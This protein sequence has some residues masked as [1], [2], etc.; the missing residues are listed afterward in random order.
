MTTTRLMLQ[1]LILG[2]CLSAIGTTAHTMGDKPVKEDSSATQDIPPPPPLQKPGAPTG[3]GNTPATAAGEKYTWHDGARAHTIFLNPTTIA[4]FGAPTNDN[5]AAVKRALPSVQP[6]RR[7][8]GAQLWRLDGG[9]DA[10]AAIRATLAKQPNAKLSPVFTDN[11]GGAGRMRA[12]PGNVIVY[13]PADWNEAT[14][15]AWAQRQG[16]VI[17]RKMDI[18]KNA[19]I[20]KTAPGLPALETA[21]R[22]YASGEVVRA[23]PDWWQET[24]TR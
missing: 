13:L 6:L 9:T 2:S 12:L 5:G 1:A 7:A 24:S 15:R 3:K 4:E 14:V 17:D 16:V 23:F 21:N 11:A 22:L 20:V 10:T 19:Y 8:G 18:G